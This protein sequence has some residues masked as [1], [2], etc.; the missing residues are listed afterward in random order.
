MSSNNHH[1]EIK[2]TELTKEQ[3][4][5]AAEFLA[6]LGWKDSEP[7]RTT[8]R[9]DIARIV[10]WYGALRYKSGLNKTGSLEI[11]ARLIGKT[12]TPA[13]KTQTEFEILNLTDLI[14]YRTP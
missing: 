7:S 5:N 8:K 11:P 4:E 10:A 12:P 14:V 2:G 9:S 3:L 13:P 1:N 6:L